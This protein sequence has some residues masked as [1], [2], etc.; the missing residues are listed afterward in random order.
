MEK[1]RA[2]PGPD[3]GVYSSTGHWKRNY[4][5]GEKTLF[6]IC[7]FKGRRDGIIY[8]LTFDTEEAAIAAGMILDCDEFNVWRALE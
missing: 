3:S 1:K 5:K 2:S 7:L 8:H 4:H 6:R